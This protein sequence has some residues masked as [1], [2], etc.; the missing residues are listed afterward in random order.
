METIVEELRKDRE[1]GARRLEGEY[2]AGLMTLARRFC[3]DE[4]DAEE[5]VNRT[6]AAVVEGIDGYVEQ[7]AFFGWMCQILSNL[8]AADV[9][10]KSNRTESSDSDAVAGATDADAT[11]R[12]FR[13]VDAS[14]LRDAVAALPDNMREVLLLHYFLDMPVAKI[15]RFL[16]IPS[17]TVLSRLHYARL[18]LAGKLGVAT[19][20]PGVKM[21]LLALLLAAGLAAGRALYTLGTAVL[22]TRAESAVFESHAENAESAEPV[23][24][25]ESAESAEPVPAVPEVSTVP[26]NPS[27]P[28]SPAMNAKSFLAAAAIAPAAFAE[29][30]VTPRYYVGDSLVAM[31]DAVCNATNAAGAFVHDNAATTWLDL[32]GNGRDF[33]VTA[34]GSWTDTTF[35]FDGASA[36]LS[37]GLP[38]YRTQEVR[39]EMDSGRWPFC[40]SSQGN[41]VYQGLVTAYIGGTLRLNQFEVAWNGNKDTKMRYLDASGASSS[42]YTT[43]VTYGKPGKGSVDCFVDGSA[44]TP[45]TKA[46]SWESD[47]RS[48]IGDRSAG[49]YAGKGRIQ[50]IRLYSRVLTDAEI[51]RNALVDRVRF[52]N[53]EPPEAVE[54]AV[55]CSQVA[56]AGDAGCAVV[57]LSASS[58]GWLASAL[59]SATVE[60]SA[61]PDFAA[62]ASFPAAIEAGGTN[63]V[64]VLTGLAP[65]AT[66]Y[67]RAVAAN[68]LGTEGVSDAATVSALSSATVTPWGVSLDS[69]AADS[70]VSA[71]LSVTVSFL[72]SGASCDLRAIVSDGSSTWTN[73]VASGL[74]A[75]GT[76]PCAL[77]HLS[78]GT[79][80]TVS[81]LASC[82]GGAA[83]ATPPASFSTPA[84]TLPTAAY[85]QNGLILHLDAIENALDASGRPVHASNPTT[86]TD[87]TGKHA[88]ALGGSTMGSIA[89]GD[90]AV[91]FPASEAYVL[92]S[93]AADVSDAVLGGTFTVEAALKLDRNATGD[94][95]YAAYSIGSGSYTA[96]RTLCFDMRLSNGKRGCIQYNANAWKS[97][98]VNF[99][100]AYAGNSSTIAATYALAGGGSAGSD[101]LAYHDGDYLQTIQNYGDY[102][103]SSS[104]DKKLRVR[105]YGSGYAVTD[106]YAFRAYGRTLSAAEI[107]TNALV[108]SVRFF[109]AAPPAPLEPSVSFL[110]IDAGTAGE[111]Q[112]M[113]TVDAFG[114]PSVELASLTLEYAA[115]PDFAGAQTVALAAGGAAGGS[116]RL[117]GLVPGGTYWARA[118]A[119]N[120]IG[121]ASSSE[122]LRFTA[123]TGQ[124]MPPAFTVGAVSATAATASF[125]FTLT[126]DGGGACDGWAVVSH[127]GHVATNALFSGATAP[128]AATLSL[129][130][131]APA[132]AYT[133]T[134]C[135]TNAAGLAAEPAALAFTTG[136]DDSFV[137]LYVTNGLIALFDGICNATNAAGVPVHSDAPDAW[138]DLTGHFATEDRGTIAYLPTGVVYA[139]SG[140]TYTWCEDGAAAVDAILAGTFTVEALV[141]FD[142]TAGDADY[143]GLYS[144]GSGYETT[145]RLL[146]FDPRWQ[147]GKCGAIHYNLD[148][149]NNNVMMLSD[150]DL[151]RMGTYTVAGG[152][153]N[154]DGSLYID[155]AYQ[156]SVPNGRVYTIHSDVP[157][158]FSIRRY[159]GKQA[160]ALYHSFRVYDRNL[161]AEEI[162]H[163]RAVD[164]ARFLDPAASLV[165]ADATRDGDTIL[166]TL[167]RTGRTA[168]ADVVLHA[169]ADYGVYEASPT[170]GAFAEN[171]A[172]AAITVAIPASARYVRFSAGELVSD[173][174][175]VADIAAAGG[176]SVGAASVSGVTATGATVSSSVVVPS[177]ADPVALYAAY[178]YAPDELVWTNAL[179]GASA[180]AAASG[181]ASGALA[182]LVPNRTYYLRVFGVSGGETV[183]SPAD[184]IAVFTTPAGEGGA[185]LLGDA[186]TVVG[187]ETG[188]TLVF[189][190]T[191]DGAASI[192]VNGRA[193]AIAADGTWSV[194]FSGVT[195]G[196]ATDYLVSARNAAGDL[197]ALPVLT[198][199]TRAASALPDPLPSS[200]SQRTI[201][202]SSALAVQGANETT[203]TLLTGPSA[204]AL[205][206]TVST[207]V[208]AGASPSFSLSWRAPTFGETVYWAVRIENAATDPANGHWVSTSAVSSFE[209]KDESLYV[210]QDV[211]GDR[212]GDW[213]DPAHWTSDHPG[214]CVGYPCTEDARARLTRGTVSLDGAYTIKRIGFGADGTVTIAGPGSLTVADGTYQ[215][216][217]LL[218]PDGADVVFADGAT[219]NFPTASFAISATARSATNYAARLAVA[220][221]ASLRAVDIILSYGGVFEVDDATARVDGVYFN[222]GASA[223]GRDAFPATG[224][225]LRLA[226]AAPELTVTK[227]IRCYNTA[228]C[229]VGGA[230]EFSVPKGGWASAPISMTGTNAG[231]TFCGDSK[232]SDK[233]VPVL[234]RV[235]AD[236]KVYGIGGRPVDIELATWRVKHTDGAALMSLIAPR[237]AETN[238]EHRRLYLA[239]DDLSLRL[240]YR[241]GGTL[242]LIK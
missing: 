58:V 174:L 151:S 82:G 11:E 232:V 65:G 176:L 43:T 164:V 109:G 204:D 52:A 177:S 60:C 143:W 23:S 212:T 91:V 224:G 220:G 170:G 19:R 185:K 213:S 228:G 130:G 72:P 187:Q 156:R 17:G 235:A 34:N 38:Y 172:T 75:A 140:L 215:N 161:T 27:T 158:H 171:S 47:G 30:T 105:H 179:S 209:T 189:S 102:T 86:W 41:Q 152:G 108:D 123:S 49:G 79:A 159:S 175:Y 214:D 144:F 192:A 163:N 31:Y 71:A 15:A 178:G 117:A 125:P 50:S 216:N 233:A 40:G 12:L 74:T 221:G 240:V 21:V 59:A 146:T 55:S 202:V 35:E 203:V 104:I 206:N 129:A 169:A 54:P 205:T 168:A 118:V 69:A 160:R 29:S 95:Q 166:A 121:N 6:F 42:P 222:H 126:G 148:G 218:V 155:A 99:L 131:L 128:H 13:D 225:L 87:L 194:T 153:P 191:S 208:A 145:P 242:V 111:A 2:R 219:A 81:I 223:S 101:A 32:S 137:N 180:T 68:D 238:P 16:A 106:F 173:I 22:E 48:V 97:S 4:G 114:W 98:G 230:V 227:N 110:S 147:S 132:T 90:A 93:D 229:T 77:T 165:V 196:A 239:A 210:W 18:A 134:I 9:R 51:A 64:A 141:G 120:D 85:V 83:D 201:S 103:T 241:G 20:K 96:P 66:V 200:A 167:V 183:D 198:V 94:N 119:V 226:G 162:A 3:S 188:D 231:Y 190:G 127:G 28:E 25:A 135:V 150:G 234:V 157:K 14:L 236:S 237:G 195:P 115:S 133:A 76:F 89:F 197:D 182:G 88:L 92:A 61:T 184:A 100:N 39:L 53:A 193:A 136:T 154:A 142:Q 84:Q 57:R 199:T 217:W 181:V 44:T 36:T 138:T 56:G 62:P 67:V 78:P 80:Y 70:S 107:S 37:P 113:W 7:S 124:A 139:A 1:S 10:R 46:N 5:L 211:D 24:R 8:H 63:G 73:A 149:W 33:T 26:F 186:V 116:I 45:V 112:L 207:V 122:V